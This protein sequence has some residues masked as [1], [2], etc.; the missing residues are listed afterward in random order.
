MRRVVV[1]GLGAITPIG[2]NVKD[3]WEAVQNG[4][5]GIAPITLYPTE[6]RKVKL[7][8]EVKNYQPED[9]MEKRDAKKMDRFTQFAIN[10]KIWI[11]ELEAVGSKKY[12]ALACI[13][14]RLS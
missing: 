10:T 3:M 5:C 14:R 7:A 1:T 4:V 2:N 13:Q 12:Y 6:D 9:Y 8:G 11:I